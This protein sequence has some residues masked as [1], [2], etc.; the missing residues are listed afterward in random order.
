MN[1]QQSSSNRTY[2]ITANGVTQITG[3]FVLIRIIVN[4]KGASS[5]RATI[6]DSA[7]TNENK[8]GTIDTTVTERVIECGYPVTNGIRVVVETG[9]APDLTLVYA[10]I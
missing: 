3:R 6:Y 9:T 8:I 1:P 10:E 2:N 4:I 5:N 7:S